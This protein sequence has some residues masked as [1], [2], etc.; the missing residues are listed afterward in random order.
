MDFLFSLVTLSSL[1][2]IIIIIPIFL[3]FLSFVI[4]L[5]WIHRDYI[6]Q[7]SMSGKGQS[8]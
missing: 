3:L 8:Q 6:S 5:Q 2:F 7:K 4:S 1:F